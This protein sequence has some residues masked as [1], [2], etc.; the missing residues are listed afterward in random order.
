MIHYET[1]KHNYFISTN[2]ALIDVA[3]VHQYLSEESYWAKGIPLATVEKS[4]ANS[5]CFGMY[6]GNK[7]IGFARLIT[8]R[9]AFAYLC[10][11]FIVPAYQ[12][13]GLGKWLLQ[14]IHAHPDLQALR[15]WMLA[16]R[17]A[18]G[19][20]AQFG[21]EGINDEQAKRFMQLHNPNVYTQ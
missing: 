9:T 3:A 12:G 21:W 20:Y 4:I 5:L 15:R 19:L 7:L 11:V 16:T 17:D 13:K 18:H 2:P 14:T 10:D 1:K 8:D 6:E